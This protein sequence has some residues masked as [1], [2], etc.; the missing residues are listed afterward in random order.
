MSSKFTGRVRFAVEATEVF[1][2]VL[3]QGVVKYPIDL[4]LKLPNGTSV[5]QIDLAY[6]K[7]E[8]GIGSGVTTVYDLVGSLTDKSGD[9]INFAKVFCI[10]IRNRSDTAANYLLI[11]PDATNGFGVL[12]SNIGFWADASD[13]NVITADYDADSGDGG[14][15]ILNSRTGVPCAAGSTDELAVITGGSASAAGWD[16]VILG[17]SA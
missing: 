4:E 14:W 15:A 6:G 3:E 16:I 7:R 9:T 1:D 17:R 10:A 8:S 13:R 2:S 11:G 5:G 12:A